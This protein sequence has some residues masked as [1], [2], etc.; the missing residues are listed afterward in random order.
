[1]NILRRAIEAEKV[2]DKQEINIVCA[3]PLAE[4]Y[5]KVLDVLYDKESPSAVAAESQSQ[6][7]TL[8][9]HLINA[10]S[11]VNF[12]IPQEQTQIYGVIKPEVSEDDIINVATYLATPGNSDNFILVVDA[13]DPEILLGEKKVEETVVDVS[14]GS[15]GTVLESLGKQYGVRV[16]NKFS[17]ALE[18]FKK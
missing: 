17:D 15:L 2:E 10:N 7:S 6:D 14:P 11:G 13:T 3:G 12:Q 18:N 4:A 1:M 8:I 9:K 16:Y 5:T